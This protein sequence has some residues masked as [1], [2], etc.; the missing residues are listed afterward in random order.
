M[1]RQEELKKD[2]A[3]YQKM[4][5]SCQSELTTLD[6]SKPKHFN[7]G[8]KCPEGGFRLFIKGADGEIRVYDEEGQT[9]NNVTAKECCPYSLYEIKGNLKDFIRQAELN[10]EDLTEFKVYESTGGSFPVRL[11]PSNCSCINLDGCDFD[12]KEIV[13]MISKLTQMLATFERRQKNE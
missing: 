1:I 6:K 11:T 8:F 10:Q 9:N 12:S 4:I 2:I 7:W 3:K 13:K 5:E